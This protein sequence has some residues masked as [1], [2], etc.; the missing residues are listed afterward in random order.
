MGITLGTAVTF[1]GVCHFSTSKFAVMGGYTNTARTSVS[2]AVQIVDVSTGS[3]SVTTLSTTLI[4][5]RGEPRVLPF[6]DGGTIKCMVVG[7]YDGAGNALAKVELYDPNAANGSTSGLTDM[8][9]RR[10]GH[11]LAKWGSSGI[12][13][14]GGISQTGG[15]SLSYLNTTETYTLSGGSWTRANGPGMATRAYH[16]AVNKVGSD[17]EVVLLGGDNAGTALNTTEHADQ[18]G[19]PANFTNGNTMQQAR[20]HLS[21]IAIDQT[22]S[23]NHYTVLAVGGQS[24]AT[25]R[26]TVEYLNDGAGG[27]GTG[28]F[29]LTASNLADA[30]T[31]F[32]LLPTDVTDKAIAI[33]GMGS[34]TTSVSVA[35]SQFIDGAA[36]PPNV[37]A[38]T[39]ALVKGR[40]GLAAAYLSGANGGAAEVIAGGI[41]KA[42]SGATPAVVNHI[43]RLQ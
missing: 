34:L 19:A 20:T 33:G 5:A 15:G 25:V 37:V 22:A 4:T 39:K 13:V 30:R 42:T 24:G 27:F 18:S 2:N 7:G 8:N 17:T 43:E 16:A 23:S 41:E 12:I 10:F 31:D 14:T 28:T 32:A 3:P 21:A 36:S 9:S 40:Y 26:N 29:S 6:N 35:T 1:P 11:A 38:G